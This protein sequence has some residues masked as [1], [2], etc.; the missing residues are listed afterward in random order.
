[1]LNN[2]FRPF[3]VKL[4]R[5]VPIYHRAVSGC[6]TPLHG[7]AVPRFRG[8]GVPE[9]RGFPSHQ[10]PVRRAAIERV[11]CQD[12]DTLCQFADTVRGLADL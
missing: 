5:Y 11:F 7:S 12:A 4:S 1:M 2:G 9:F 6:F 8:S 3:S 10:A